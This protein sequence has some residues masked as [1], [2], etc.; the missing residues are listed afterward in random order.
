MA[1]RRALGYVVSPDERTTAVLEYM[2]IGQEVPLALISCADAGKTPGLPAHEFSA[3]RSAYWA[4][5]ASVDRVARNVEDN[6][7][8]YD[9]LGDAAET[10]GLASGELHAERSRQLHD[11]LSMLR[12][13]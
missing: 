4:A 11:L 3:Y 6:Y 1:A 13:N 9:A 8:A 12:P 10:A 2:D 5:Y 7:A